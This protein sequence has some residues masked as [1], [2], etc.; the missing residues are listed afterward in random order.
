MKK[1]PAGVSLFFLKVKLLHERFSRFLNCTNDIKSRRGSHIRINL[2]LWITEETFSEKRRFYGIHSSVNAHHHE[3]VQEY[4]PLSFFFFFVVFENNDKKTRITRN[5]VFITANQRKQ[6]N[7]FQYEYES[8]II[9][10]IV[11]YNYNQVV[12]SRP[13]I[14]QKN[15]RKS[16]HSWSSISTF[17]LTGKVLFRTKNLW[18]KILCH[19]T[20]SCLTSSG[21]TFSEPTQRPFTCSKSI[22][23]I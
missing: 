6:K 9:L 17:I 13:F 3:K 4:S 19:W 10:L 12:T 2:K 21:K 23:K 16:C 7:L 8:I 14:W 1:P 18:G 20:K 11:T 5:E 22:M 15:P